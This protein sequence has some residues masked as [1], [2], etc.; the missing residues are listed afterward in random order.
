WTRCDSCAMG[1]MPVG[2]LGRLARDERSGRN[3]ATFEIRM[4]QIQ[5]GIEYGDAHPLA[6]IRRE[7]GADGTHTPRGGTFSRPLEGMY[8]ALRLDGEDHTV[9]FRGR[10][11]KN[12]LGRWPAAQ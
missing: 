1:A 2:V 6:C 3:G 5:T 10:G 4:V 7:V 12:R 9:V 11:R 8:P